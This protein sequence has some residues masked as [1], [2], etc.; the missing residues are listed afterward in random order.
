MKKKVI[1]LCSLLLAVFMIT[2]MFS[3]CNKEPE[4]PAGSGTSEDTEQSNETNDRFDEN[5]YLRDDLPKTYDFDDEFVIYTWQDQKAWEW[6]ESGTLAKTSVEEVLYK[7]QVNVEDRFG[8]EISRVYAPGSWNARHTFIQTLANHV[9]QNDHAFDLVGQYT[10]AAGVGASQG[11]YQDLNILPY[12]NLEKPWW[13][14]LISESASVGDKLYF[15]TGDITPTLIRNVEC[16]FVN[17]DLYEA[18]GIST[19]A[20]GKS[21]YDVVKDYDWT[22]DMMMKLAID[23]VDVN[24][25]MYGL[26][27]LN[28]VCADG[29]FYAGGFRL[30]ENNNGVLKV[31]DGLSNNSL[32]NWFDTVQDLFTARYADIAIGG[33]APFKEK[34]A[35]FYCGNVS[36]SQNFSKEGVDFTILPM[37][38]LNDSQTRYYTCATFW[39][40][41]YSV[42]NDVRSKEMSGMILEALASEAYRTVTDEIYYNLFQRRYN[43]SGGG[44]S[45]EMFDIL[46]DSVVFDSARMFADGLGMFGQFRLAINDPTGNWSTVYSSN[47]DAWTTKVANIYEK[48]K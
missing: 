3:A 9:N 11:L 20:D 31:S 40:T 36:D 22:L 19:A 33:A 29:F 15:C 14:S 46:S 25:G 35:I 28:D 45:A 7:R 39:V 12:I 34:N 13:P 18:Y 26:S 43:G 16:M 30:V 47:I 8:V 44:A 4:N 27:I 23:R 6:V 24:S 41:M 2:L 1:R 48:Y 38:M 32:V 21:I 10:P 17:L 37:P 42:P 5:G